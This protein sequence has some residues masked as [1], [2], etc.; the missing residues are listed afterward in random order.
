MHK[1]KAHPWE[2][3]PTMTDDDADGLRGDDVT[4]TD[5][6]GADIEA[7]VSRSPLPFDGLEAPL[8]T[9]A[10]PPAP[11]R[12]LAFVAIL[13]G[14]LL[15]G[16]IGY[17]TADIMFDSPVTAAIG[18]LIG[19]LGCAVGVGIVAGLTLRAMAEWKSVAHPEATHSEAPHSEAEA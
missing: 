4:T 13:V 19:A 16:L 8:P 1:S 11:A 18:G 3:D 7:T 9:S 6:P 14:G 12:W 15:G 5:A 10:A 17:G 2:S